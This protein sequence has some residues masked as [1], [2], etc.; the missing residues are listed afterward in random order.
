M[1]ITP[2]DTIADVTI[3]HSALFTLG[4]ERIFAE[5]KTLDVPKYIP[6]IRIGWETQNIECRDVLQT[7]TLREL[8]IVS[9]IE[10]TEEYVFTV[11]ATMLKIERDDVPHLQFL[12]AMRYY[13]AVL[14]GIDT[15]VKTWKTIEINDEK[16]YTPKHSDRG[17][18]AIANEYRGNNSIDWA[19]EQRWID[20]FLDFEQKYDKYM[21]QKAQI[22]AQESKNR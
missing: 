4:F 21:A 5:I 16:Y 1:K 7:I 11:L 2:S 6:L 13:L 10:N 9:Q 3:K 18:W 17:L 19:W 15:I 8:D 12:G 14:E 20:V 22:K